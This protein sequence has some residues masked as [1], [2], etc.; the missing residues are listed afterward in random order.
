[1]DRLTSTMT[2]G[3]RECTCHVCGQTHPVSDTAIKTSAGYTRKT[4]KKDEK[5]GV[6]RGTSAPVTSMDRHTGKQRRKGRAM[7]KTKKEKRGQKGR[8]V[9]KKKGGRVQVH[10]SRLRTDTQ[11]KRNKISGQEL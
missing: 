3:R 2:G 4:K 11:V 6:K 1:M 7:H 10:L 5:R 9:P 8:A